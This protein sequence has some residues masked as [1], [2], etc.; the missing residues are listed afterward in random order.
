M[1]SLATSFN[2]DISSWNVSKMT[3]MYSMFSNASAFNNGGVSLDSW[4]PSSCT[5][6][7]FMSAQSTAWNHE[8]PSWGQYVFAEG[9]T[10]T[11]MLYQTQLWNTANQNGSSTSTQDLLCFHKDTELL[12]Y[13]EDTKEEYYK[14]CEDIC[15]GDYLKTFGTKKI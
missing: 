14:R 15:V 8:L 11:N 2:K 3:S 9:V 1:L 6:F 7:G 10:N 12:C 5:N 4:D 13:N